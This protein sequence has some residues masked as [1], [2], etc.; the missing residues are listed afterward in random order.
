MLHDS[1]FVRK[2]E[3]LQHLL[4]HEPKNSSQGNIFKVTVIL[5]IVV[6]IFGVDNSSA[7]K[8]VGADD[9]GDSDS[10]SEQFTQWNLD[11]SG[12]V[13]PRYHFD[14]SELHEV[15]SPR[16]QPDSSRIAFRISL[17]SGL[18]NEASTHFKPEKT[19]FGSL[20]NK[21]KEERSEPQPIPSLNLNVHLA[22]QSSTSSE[23]DNSP[24]SSLIASPKSGESTPKTPIF[25][26]MPLHPPRGHSRKATHDS[27]DELLE[28]DRD[29]A[30]RMDSHWKLWIYSTTKRHWHAFWCRWSPKGE[31]LTSFYAERILEPDDKGGSEH[32]NIYHFPD[33]RGTVS[34]GY[35]MC[36]PWIISHER[37]SRQDGL[38]HPARDYLRMLLVPRGAAWVST[39]VSDGYPSAA[40]LFLHCT[41]QLRMS[42]GIVY[43]KK[44]E[45]QSVALIREDS[46]GWPSSYW[47]DF[48]EADIVAHDEFYKKFI[49]ERELRPGHG[50][51]TRADLSQTVLENVDFRKTRFAN[52][53]HE[54]NLMIL[55]SDQV[56]VVVP[57]VRHESCILAI[58]WRFSKW[59]MVL[60]ATWEADMIL[61]VSVVTYK[62]M[63]Y[64]AKNHPGRLL[65]PYYEWPDQMPPEWPKPQE[66]SR[67]FPEPR[68]NID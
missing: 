61:S 42:V 24:G 26:I 18:H 68:E 6:F 10:I 49:V 37:C 55:S 58:G 53:T 40:E 5:L 67:W 13:S 32:R 27:I 11:S 12:E 51:M 39:T 56:A 9:Q 44:R 30:L 28:K 59:I 7:E 54:D 1:A 22:R 35:E 29:M 31:L 63:M 47:D 43:N 15:E 16:Q 8:R 14:S 33:K 19:S 25:G 48:T 17:P 34:E 3:H 2:G 4:V 60:E 50:Y 65:P 64:T 66:L 41:S 45:L 62:M 36:G 52:P 38:I 57:R 20:F 23:Q 21:D 46:R